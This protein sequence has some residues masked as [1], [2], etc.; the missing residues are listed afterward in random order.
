M[1]LNAVQKAEQVKYAASLM[2]YSELMRYASALWMMALE[3]NG[4]DTETAFVPAYPRWVGDANYF[5]EARFVKEDI[6]S[7]IRTL[8]AKGVEA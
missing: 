8:K 5:K 1:E 4:H 2:G 7:L 6:D 3:E